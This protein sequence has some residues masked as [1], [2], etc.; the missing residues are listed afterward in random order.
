ML[1]LPLSTQTNGVKL[2]LLVDGSFVMDL[3]FYQRL[4]TFIAPHTKCVS[5]TRARLYRATRQ[6]R[7][8]ALRL[9]RWANAGVGGN[10][11][12]LAPYV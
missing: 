11:G 12:P 5:C 2:G 1:L 9:A 4:H 8:C 6:V 10:A 7:L 3:A